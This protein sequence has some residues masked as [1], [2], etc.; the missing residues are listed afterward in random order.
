M[1]HFAWPTQLLQFANIIFF[2]ER[3]VDEL[4]DRTFAWIGKNLEQQFPKDPCMV[5]LPTFT[6]K[7]SQM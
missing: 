6:I 2:P 3:A 4:R 7:I 1:P 5:Y